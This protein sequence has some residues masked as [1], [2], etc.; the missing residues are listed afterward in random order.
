MTELEHCIM[1]MRQE[2]I[3]LQRI[4]NLKKQLDNITADINKHDPVI[5]DKAAKVVKEDV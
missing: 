3:Y 4:E 1:L 5:I 2:K